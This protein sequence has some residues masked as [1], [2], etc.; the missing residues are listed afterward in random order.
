MQFFRKWCPNFF[1]HCHFARAV[2]FSSKTPIHT[3]ILPHEQDGV[4]DTLETIMA[5]SISEEQFQRIITLMWYLWKARNDLRFQRKS[6]SFCRFTMQL[7]QT[8]K[9]LLLVA[10]CRKTM[11]DLERRL[12]I[13]IIKIVLFTGSLA[14]FQVQDA[15]PMLRCYRIQIKEEKGWLA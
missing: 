1:F 15:S 13:W 4:Q 10:K 2:W 5:G 3:S 9:S 6:W 8:S 11:K 14:Y 7:R 12:I